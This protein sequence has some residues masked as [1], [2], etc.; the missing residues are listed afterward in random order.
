[1]LHLIDKKNR[2]IIYIFLLFFLSTF[3]NTAL[4]DLNFLDLN[5]KNIKI[6]GLGEKDNFLIK[7]DLNQVTFN[8]IFFIKKNYFNNNLN[9]NN[10]IYFFKI[11]KIYPNSIEIQ[12]VKTEFLAITNNDNKFF[13]IGS[14]GKLIKHKLNNK[15]LPH[16]FG[17]VSAKNFINFKKTINKSNLK[18]NDIN[19]FYFFPSGR[20]DIKNKDGILFKLPKD[21]LA[22]TLDMINKITKNKNFK[23]SSIIDMRIS[24][25]IIL[26]DE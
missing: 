19:E 24:N 14:N 26:Q 21:N 11:K 9:K 8:N 12:I 20:W 23:D 15:N 17:N 16:V 5:I 13:F 4:N 2:F 7:K 10:L 1:M 22:N 18:F 3:N 25:Q 6:S